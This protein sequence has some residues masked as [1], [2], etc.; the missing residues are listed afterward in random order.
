MSGD[1]VEEDPIQ[2]VIYQVPQTPST[3]HSACGDCITTRAPTSTHPLLPCPATPSIIPAP[4]TLIAIK[5]DTDYLARRRSSLFPLQCPYPASIPALE[6]FIVIKPD[7]KYLDVVKA[8][9]LPKAPSN[10]WSSPQVQPL[11]H[12]FVDYLKT[13]LLHR[14]L[15]GYLSSSDRDVVAGCRVTECRSRHW[16]HPANDPDPESSP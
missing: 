4:K 15:F 16:P 11:K 6:T 10:I 5:P 14:S 7:T 1:Y 2:S 8:F 13:S 3:R 12:R 9:P